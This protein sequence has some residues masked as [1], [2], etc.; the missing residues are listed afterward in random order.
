[1]DDIRKINFVR[2]SSDEVSSF[3]Y[4]YDYKS[5]M[6]YG[7]LYCSN[8]GEPTIVALKDGGEMMGQKQLSDS[9]IGKINRMYNCKTGLGTENWT[10]EFVE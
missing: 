4:D 6:H 10:P 8:N 9:D 7:P 3:G 2:Y 1:M 5:I